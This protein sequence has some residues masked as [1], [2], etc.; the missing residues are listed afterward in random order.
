MQR[1]SGQQTSVRL[2]QPLLQKTAGRHR[3]REGKKDKYKKAGTDSN[4]CTWRQVC[5]EMK[6]HL[7]RTVTAECRQFLIEK[8]QAGKVVGPSGVL[9]PR[10]SSALDDEE[11]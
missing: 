4:G 1:T 10:K 9:M 8:S 2:F 5:T 7:E 11:V 3:E 6:S